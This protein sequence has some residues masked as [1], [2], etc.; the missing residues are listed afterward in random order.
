VP[1]VVEMEQVDLLLM[2]LLQDLLILEGAV[3]PEE[4]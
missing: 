1:E 3:V 2:L 4:E